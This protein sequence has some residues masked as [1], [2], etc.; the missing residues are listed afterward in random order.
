MNIRFEML[1]LFD[2]KSWDTIASNSFLPGER[3]HWNLWL[4][5]DF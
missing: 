1:N 2:S 3:R 5:A 4:I